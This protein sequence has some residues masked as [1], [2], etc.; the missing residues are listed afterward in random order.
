MSNCSQKIQ[1]YKVCIRVLKVR[2][3][4]LKKYLT[5]ILK[6]NYFSVANIQNKIAV[7]L[8]FYNKKLLRL[9]NFL[10]TFA[11]FDLYFY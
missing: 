7:C 10:Y 3:I 4:G 5:K 11:T 6:L 1:K 9:S 8:I 2:F